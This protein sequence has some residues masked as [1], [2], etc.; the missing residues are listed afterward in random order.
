MRASGLVAVVVLVTTA[1]AC[2]KA[3]RP[4]I[5]THSAP[6][7]DVLASPPDSIEQALDALPGLAKTTLERTGVPGLAV[8]VVQGGE[9]VFAEGYGVKSLGSD[10]AVNADTVF[11]IASVSKSV[12]ATVVATQV[13]AGVV[14]WS[15]PVAELLP[16]FTLADPWV[17]KHVTVGDLY[18]H[19]SGLPAEAGDDLEVVGYD[20]D[21][22]LS[23]LVYEPL[24]P[25][26]AIYNYANFGMTAGAEAVAAAAGSSWEDLAEDALFE[27][28]G[29]TS[30]SARYEDFL[31]R[32]NRATIHAKV[33]DSFKA[34]Y[35][36]NPDAQSPAGGISSNVN[37]LAK[38]MQLILAD[39]VF[40]GK[41]L[42]EP[43]ALVPALSA[44]MITGPIASPTQRT[45][46]Y[47]FGF[48]VGVQ[49]S[50]RVSLSHS[51]AFVL[52]A[53]T[54]FMMLPELDIG[55]IV[56]TNAGPVGA[57]EAVAAQFMDLVQFGSITRDWITD[58]AAALAPYYAPA[59]DLVG[60]ARPEAPAAPQPLQHYVGEYHNDYFGPATVRVIGDRL[61]VELGPAD[62]RLPL[63]HWAG[64]TFS[65]VPVGEYAPHGSLSSATFTMD[66]DTAKALTLQ[67]FDTR[68]LGTWTR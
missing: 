64:D 26:R 8:A 55:I 16:D 48:G 65:F 1:S 31:A 54:S 45:G 60:K 47:G 5:E 29:M 43:D 3:E 23:H 59:G 34:L 15:T 33:G 42:I 53:A 7:E 21:Y 32:G 18:S 4:R 57:A 19:R 11:Q 56:L 50:G 6:S 9:T 30:T 20:R 68:G 28:L 36:R 37:D 13:S 61:V 2:G 39:G 49:P 25:F 35:E 41:Q 62:Y 17:T 51:G 52:G 44:Q 46:Q 40:N 66:G 22:V 63:D 58:Y 67:F 38:W 12:G 24:D 10:D 27:P 14:E